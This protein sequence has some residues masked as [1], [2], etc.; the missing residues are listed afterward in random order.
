MRTAVTALAIAAAIAGIV[1]TVADPLLARTLML[2]AICVVLWLSE[3]LPPFIPTMVLLGGAA[4]L[5]QPFGPQFG[6]A[7]IIGWAADPVLVLFFG[8]FV[9]GVTAHRHGLDVRLAALVV[10]TSSGSSRRLVALTMLSTALLSMWMSN[11]AAAAVMAAVLRPLVNTPRAGRLPGKAVFLAVAVG[12]NLGGIATPI[13]TGPN[14]IAIAAAAPGFQ[15]TFLRWMGL[16]LPLTLGMLLAGYVLLV[17]R[18]RVGSR[19][20]AAPI[21]EQPLSFR[22]RIALGVM[23]LGI[24]T[25]L[26]EPLHG[27]PAAVVALI[28]ATVIFSSG[29]LTTN[30]LGAIDWSTLG[31]IA[32][33]IALGRLLEAGGV[34]ARAPQMLAAATGSESA[35]LAALVVVGAL[36]SAFMSNT[37]TA[38]LLIPLASVIYPSPAMAILIA[39]A[40]SFGMPFV[41]STPPNAIVHGQAGI[42]AADLL[43]VG[44]PLMALGCVVLI[45]TGP[46]ALAWLGVP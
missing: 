23:V 34:L 1:S 17:L 15:I 38:A 12:A 24:L 30:D 10:R 14:A 31:L 35:H 40:C 19:F 27:M 29:L 22:G 45:A 41:I 9:L 18:Y 25:W 26:L 20:S 36:M 13:G 39:I 16:A 2:A 44:L 28:L 3:L 7:E 21:A 8:G 4:L 6:F 37:A 5:L 46:A 32:G 42:T 11:V 43:W 33:G